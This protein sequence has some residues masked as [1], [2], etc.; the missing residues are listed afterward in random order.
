[1]KKTTNL[2]EQRFRSL[3]KSIP[4]IKFDTDELN[5]GIETELEH[6]NDKEVATIIAKQHLAEDPKYYSKLKKFHDEDENTIG[7]GAFGP[8]AE[9]GHNGINNTDWYATGDARVPMHLGTQSRL[10]KV[11]K[12]KKRKNKKSRKKTKKK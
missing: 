10:G 7:G 3:F 2:F 6:T 4:D 9:T 8:A 5:V 1:M 12:T 11:S